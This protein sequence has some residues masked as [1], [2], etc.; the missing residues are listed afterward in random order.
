MEIISPTDRWQD[1]RKKIEE[2]FAIGINWVWIVEPPTRSI[3]VFTASTEFTQYDEAQTLKGEGILKGF[4]LKVSELF[5][6]VR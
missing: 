6:E 5:A 4:E 2:Y 3:L 1:L